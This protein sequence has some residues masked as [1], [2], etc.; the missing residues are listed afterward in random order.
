MSKIQVCSSNNKLIDI[1]LIII[2]TLII[3]LISLPTERILFE[4]DNHIL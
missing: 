2:N 4:I 3:F 1:D